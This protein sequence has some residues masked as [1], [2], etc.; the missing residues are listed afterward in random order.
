M[1]KDRTIGNHFF[2]PS[3][4][5]FE[6]GRPTVYLW[7]IS[8]CPKGKGYYFRRSNSLPFQYLPPSQGAEH[9][10]EKVGSNSGEFLPLHADS[11]YANRNPQRL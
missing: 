8:I 1:R 3:R 11:S 2:Q 4:L 5:L 6:K 10:K 7:C 9:L